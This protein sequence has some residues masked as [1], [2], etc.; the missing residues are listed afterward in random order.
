MSLS[1]LPDYGH[2]QCPHCAQ[3]FDLAIASPTFAET[4]CGDVLLYVMC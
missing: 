2:G 3:D 1:Y 4:I